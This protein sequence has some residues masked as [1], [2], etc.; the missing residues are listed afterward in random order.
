MGFFN[1]F[2]TFELDDKH[3]SAISR[4]FNPEIIGDDVYA[5]S[6]TNLASWMSKLSKDKLP[7]EEILLITSDNFGE[8]AFSQTV[9]IISNKRIVKLTNFPDPFTN[10]KVRIFHINEIADVQLKV[11]PSG[12]FSA[13]VLNNSAL[14]FANM[15]EGGGSPPLSFFTNSIF[16]DIN[17]E[18]LFLEFDTALKKARGIHDSPDPSKVKSSADTDTTSFQHLKDLIDA[19]VEIKK[20]NFVIQER[21]ELLEARQ[22][23]LDID[24]EIRSIVKSAKLANNTNLITDALNYYHTLTKEFPK[25]Q[26]DDL[27]LFG[28]RL[29][30]TFLKDAKRETLEDMIDNIVK[31]WS[32]PLILIISDE[33]LQELNDELTKAAIAKIDAGDEEAI[34]Q[35]HRHLLLEE[36]KKDLS[37][38]AR[39]NIEKFLPAALAGKYI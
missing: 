16:F 36:T 8:D 25:H 23:Q 19:Y 15:L 5:T 32:Q 27:E 37:P 39:A 20:E 2:K 38:G 7:D 30:G 33:E 10:Q 4:H 9:Y 22:D 24:K 17:R 18:D 1:A 35:A 26:L 21:G 31:A 14:P 12:R 13:Y 6:L 11:Y 29:F 28:N 34:N 3:K